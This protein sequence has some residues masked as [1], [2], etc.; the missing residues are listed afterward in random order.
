MNWISPNAMHSL[1]WALLHFLWQG[2]ALAALAA[3]AMALCRR[4]SA[5]YLIGVATLVLML[6]APVATFLFYSQQHAAIAGDC[7]FVAARR[8]LALRAASSQRTARRAVASTAPSLDAIPWLVASVASRSGLLQPALRGRISAAGA[9]APQ[10]VDLSS[11]ARVLE[12]CYTLQDQLGID[13][14]IQYCECKWLQAPAVIGWFRPIVFLPATALTGLSED[15]LQ[16]RDCAR[17]GSHPALRSFCECVPGLRRDPALLPSRSLVAEQT[18]SRGTRALLRR[19]GGLGLRQ[20]GRV[21]A[22]ADADGRMAK[23]ASVSR[24]R[25]IAVLL[26]ERIV[27]VLGL[28]TLGT[29]IRSIGLTGSMLCLTAALVAGNALLGIAHPR[30][31]S[32]QFLS[33]KQRRSQRARN[34]RSA[35]PATT[36]KPSAAQSAKSGAQCESERLQGL[37]TSMR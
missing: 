27:R 7:E 3:A 34:N 30:L 26:T 15:Q 21:R 22:R 35:K 14:A 18:H 33:C 36:P 6:I 32:R 8:A 19:N 13:R 28:K 17:T 37:L 4:T 11:S 25:P 10:A 23:R 16:V 2:T 29:G 24:W 1:G 31:R 9:R 20:C 5:R 12:I